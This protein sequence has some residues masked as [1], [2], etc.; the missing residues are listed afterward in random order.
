MSPTPPLP[1]H[2]WDALPAEA[3]ALIAA[4]QAPIEALRAE[5]RDLQARLD[6]DS[7]NSSKPPSS[8]PL[9]VKRR[10]P[11]APSGKRRGGQPG[12][13]RHA[14]ALVPP[15]RLSAAVD[16]MPAACRRCG[17]QLRGTDPTPIRHQV[18]ELPEVR[19]EVVEYRR[20][21]LTCPGCGVTTRAPLPAGVPAG[22]FGPRLL[23]TIGLLTGAYRLSKR[24]VRAAMADLLGLAIST[25]M[26]AKAERLAAGAVAEPVDRIAEAIRGAPALSVD[27]TGWREGHER[28]WLWTAVGPEATLFRIDRSRGAD[29][30][31][32]LVGEPIGP[33]II[34][35]RFPTYNR[36]PTR[37]VC[38]A[39]TIRTQS[40]I[41]LIARY[42]LGSEAP[43]ITRPRGLLRGAW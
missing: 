1:P 15:E 14:R 34:S 9:H 21:R 4:M 25:G 23:A 5:V 31:H 10:P 37:Q 43:G 35:D 7:T 42:L 11:R 29:A 39:H 26:I 38:W 6:A 27:E 18:A 16:C 12:H 13:P 28:A 33:V 3:R 24:Q 36:A 8:D 22:A 40:T 41:R 20:H 17:H 2:V 19:P 32:A 30:L